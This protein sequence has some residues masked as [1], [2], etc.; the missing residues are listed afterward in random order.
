M[1]DYNKGCIYMIKH[2]LDYNNE[3]VYIGSCC[4]FTRRK[5]EHKSRCNNP[6]DKH[7]NIKL[8]QTIRE[9]GGWDNWVMVRLHNFSCNEKYELNLEERKIIDLYQSKLNIQL[10][11]RTRKEHYE[12]NKEQINEYY[13]KWYENNKEHIN[14]YSKKWYENNKEKIMEKQ[15]IYEEKNKE[16]LKEYRK[17]YYEE[18]KEERNEYAKKSYENNKEE[19]K[20]KITCECGAIVRKYYIT[21]HCESLKHISFLNLDNMKRN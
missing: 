1:P 2:N 5:Y 6:N 20:K 15:K 7:H 16:K 14:E 4:N 3:N 12:D 13:K 19:L 17:K 10:P 9:N 21:K 11:T 18:H 8:Y